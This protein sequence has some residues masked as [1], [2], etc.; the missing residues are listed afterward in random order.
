MKRKKS[1]KGKNS[2]LSR[3]N[4]DGYI[5]D[6]EHICKLGYISSNTRDWIETNMYR[7]RECANCYEVEF[8]SKLLSSKI[9]FIHQAPFIFS[10]K[11]Y[12][13][14]FFIPAKHL[15]IE[16][17]GIY[18]ESDSQSRYDRFRDQCFNGHKISVVRIPNQAVFNEKDL[19]ILLSKYFEL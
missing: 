13:A 7:L 19:N 16:I 10:G 3:H 12:F 17:D 18:H 5:R 14:D 6:L 8:A 1:K 15:I 11:I 9:Q 2:A 4:A